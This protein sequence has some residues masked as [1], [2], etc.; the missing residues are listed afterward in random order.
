MCPSVHLP[1][2]AEIRRSQ[3]E[4]GCEVLL[5]R[6]SELLVWGVV[7]DQGEASVYTMYTVHCSFHC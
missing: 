3:K 5:R 4:G 7:T 1:F 2:Y 6:Q